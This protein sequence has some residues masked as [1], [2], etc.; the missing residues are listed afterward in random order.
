MSV[1]VLLRHGQSQWNLENRFT[2]WT[3]VPLSAQGEKDAHA[4]GRALKGMMFD[5]AFT[6]RL[7]RAQ[8]TLTIVLAEMGQGGTP[9]EYDSALNE[10]HYGDLQGL[11]KAEMAAKYGEEQVKL[12]RRSY[13]T[14]PPNGESIEDCERRTTPFFVHYILPLLVQKK[15]VIVSAHGNSM[16]P[17]FKYLD[18]LDNDTTATLEVGL[19]LPYIYSFEGDRVVHKEV[20]TVPGLVAT[21]TA[22]IHGQGK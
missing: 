17:I 6:S 20:R 22:D 10:R 18:H 5:S 15:N 11:N 9:V 1:L 8:D 2:G 7:K 12:W 3:D 4:C 19:C 14:R 16:R 21:G 13:A